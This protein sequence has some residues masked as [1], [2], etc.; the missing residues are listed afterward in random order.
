MTH[1]TQRALPT[2]IIVDAVS[3][4][5]LVTEEFSG[6]FQ[7][8]HI[9]SCAS[10]KAHAHP[11]FHQDK[12]AQFFTWNDE[13]ERAIIEVLRALHPIAVVPG[14]E[15]AVALSDR[16]AKQL[17][18]LGN[19]PLTTHLRRNKFAMNE[20]VKQQGLLTTPQHISHE[21]SELKQWYRQQRFSKGVVKPLDSAG[22]D[23]VYICQTPEQVEKAAQIITGKNNSMH[24]KN[25]AALIQKFIEGTEYVVNT[26]SFKGQNWLTDIWKVHKRLQEGRNLYD[27]DDLCDPNSPEASACL[28]YTLKVLPAIGLFTG[29]GHT[30]LIVSAEGPQLL[31][32]G[33]RASGAANPQAIRL[34]TGTDQLMLMRYAYTAPDI[35]ATI[36]PIYQLRKHLR[37]VHAIASFIK[38]FSHQELQAFLSTLGTFVSVVMKLG[39]GTV[40]KPTTDVATCPAAFFLASTNLEEIEQDYES[41]RKWEST[42]L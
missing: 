38:P 21:P 23:D 34:A 16:L 1:I 5:A 33:A 12:F 41:Y 10:I 28:D 13:N 8:I 26:V 36:P 17:S 29:A 15:S 7:L 14:N 18:L 4:G 24:V 31:E 32:T 25:H 39:D 2:L 37:C 20:A 3:A 35:L 30:E 11:R 22:S 19:T 9:E 42:N 6:N 40:L 27:Y